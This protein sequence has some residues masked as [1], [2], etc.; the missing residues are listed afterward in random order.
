MIKKKS[1]ADNA[2]IRDVEGGSPR[3]LDWLKAQLGVPAHA[4]YLGFGV[5]RLE[6]D[7]FLSVCDEGVLP[8]DWQWSA[9]VVKAR[10]F[11]GWSEVLGV[12]ERCADARVVLM[13]D[14]GEEVW[15]FPAR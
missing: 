14:Y 2:A 1:A 9:S 8:V 12:V 10:C 15:V 13:F 5:H 11:D 3:V 6:A 7:V 4:V